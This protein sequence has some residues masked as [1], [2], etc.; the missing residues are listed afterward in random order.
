MFSLFTFGAAPVTSP[1]VTHLCKQQPN[2]GLML[3]F[4]NENDMV[5][6][7]DAPYLRSLVDLYR[8]SYSLPPSRASTTSSLTAPTQSTLSGVTSIWP[9]P[10]PT[11]QLLGDIILLD[12]VVTTDDEK[13]DRGI[14]LMRALSVSPDEL[15]KLIF[16]DVE[17]HRRKAYMERLKAIWLGACRGPAKSKREAM[18]ETLLK[19]GDPDIDL[20]LAKEIAEL[21]A[22]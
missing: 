3:S 2:V 5:A 1:N 12:E 14:P 15:S 9:L 6:K 13:L 21:Y 8:A 20:E 19:S 10:R 7:A 18:V 11:F 16:C 17:V 22:T 4:I